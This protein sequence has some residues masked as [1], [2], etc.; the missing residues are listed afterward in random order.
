MH[1]D[2]IVGYLIRL[3]V[4]LTLNGQITTIIL[5]NLAIHSIF[6]IYENKYLTV[7][8]AIMPLKTYSNRGSLGNAL[9][10]AIS[11]RVL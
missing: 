11:F 6:S 4:I 7:S 3:N 10:L 8:I 9:S 2:L 5:A 1:N